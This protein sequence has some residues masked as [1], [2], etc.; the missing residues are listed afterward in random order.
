MLRTHK[1]GRQADTDCTSTT[2]ARLATNQHKVTSDLIGQWCVTQT[3]ADTKG[4]ASE[5]ISF[6]NTIGSFGFSIRGYGVR[7]FDLAAL[8]LWEWLKGL[9]L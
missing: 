2:D 8:S 6:L 3:D 9:T 7:Y 1:T 5:R 4:R